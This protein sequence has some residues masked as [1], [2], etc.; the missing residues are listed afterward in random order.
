MFFVS[1]I[2]GKVGGAAARQLLQEGK[3]VR[4][5]ARDPQKAVEWSQKGVDVRQGD[6]KDADAVA[7]ALKGV[8]G[9][10]LMLPPF[11]AP[12]P[13]FPEAQP[14]IASYRQALAQTPPPRLVVLSSIGSQ[15]TSGLGMITATHMLE[16]ALADVPCPTAFV[17]PGS[18]LENYLFGLKAAQNGTF[19][20]YLVPTERAVP[21]VGTE[22]I[23]KEVARLLTGEGWN[24]KRIVELGSPTSPDDLARALSEVLG[25]PVQAQAI[26]RDKWA[27]SL[28]AQG[29]PAGGTWAF[30]EMEDGFNSGWIGFGVAGT[31]PVAATLTPAQVFAQANKK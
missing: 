9:A 31:E 3:S 17:R 14:I 7:D 22:D 18:F 13:G 10:F 15:Q 6:W 23:G 12:K 21:M 20:S 2:T 28:E 24:G 1:G 11:A 5:L 19:P 16:V 8:E 25:R 26:P 30:E 4:G 27:A 29:M